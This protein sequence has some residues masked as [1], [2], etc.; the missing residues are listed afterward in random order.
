MVDLAGGGDDGST[1]LLGGGR[2]RKDDPRIEAYG[3]VDEASSAIGLAKALSAHPR[4]RAICEELQRGLYALGAELATNPA[5]K[6]SFGT[7]TEAGVE[8]LE[9]FTAE[10]EKA[11][12]MPDGFILPGSTPASGALD[13][14]R[15][16]AR[17]AER[18]C[19]ALERG[20]GGERMSTQPLENPQVRRWLNRLSLLLFVLARYEEGLSG[21]ASKPA[22]RLVR[23]K[24]RSG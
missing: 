22:K 3:T 17:R 6:A 16:I 24:L 23:P 15:A 18:R 11:V 2:A 4:V 1:G 5:S 14:A 12:P 19:L 9:E 20:G 21:S 7:T 8:R 13:L 10:L